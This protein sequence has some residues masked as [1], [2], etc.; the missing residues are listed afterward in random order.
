MWH[1][2]KSAERSVNEKE[3]KNVYVCVC[4]K[5]LVNQS[6]LNARVVDTLPTESLM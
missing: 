6:R 2:C 4:V 1:A 3:R 5:I